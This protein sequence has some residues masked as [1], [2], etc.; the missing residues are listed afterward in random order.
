MQ[1]ATARSYKLA[2]MISSFALFRT[3]APR[4][5]VFGHHFG[6]HGHGFLHGLLHYLAWATI[7]HFLFRSGGIFLVLVVIAVLWLVLRRRRA[8]YY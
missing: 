8:A 7:F 5:G 2:E 3:R 1:A 4:L 6:S